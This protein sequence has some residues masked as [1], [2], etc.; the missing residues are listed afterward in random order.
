MAPAFARAA[1][2][3]EPRYRLGRLDTEAFPDLAAP[4]GIRSLPTLLLF[5][6]GREIRRH[7]GAV[8]AGSIVR[9][10]TA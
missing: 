4:F 10:V 7:S 2:T 8:D 9:W 6:D 5:K 1:T 3:L